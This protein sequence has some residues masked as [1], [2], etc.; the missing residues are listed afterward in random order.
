MEEVEMGSTGGLPPVLDFYPLTPDRWQDFEDLFGERGAYG[1]CWCMWWRSTR[2]E[3]EERGSEG[4]RQAMKALVD[5]GQVPGILAYRQGQAVGWCSVAPR[6]QYGALERSRVLKRLDERPVWSLVCL[7]V[8]R[9]HRGRGVAEALIRAAV[10]Y[11]QEQGG[12]VVEAYPTQPRE[13]RLPPVSS[14]M[15]LPAMFG[16]AGFVECARPSKSRVIMRYSL[17]RDAE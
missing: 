13:K 17:D 1:G 9:D 7:F 10:D 8:D 14:Y 2:R 6:E 5:S 12:A 16:R 15:G 3:F 11:V 4:N